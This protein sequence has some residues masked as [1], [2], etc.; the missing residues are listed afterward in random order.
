MKT[1]I[2]TF[3]GIVALGIIGFTNINAAFV[4]ITPS[5]NNK[6]V[7][8]MNVVT[9]KEEVLTIEAWMV[10][11]EFWT[12]TTESDTME[13]EKALEVEGWMTNQDLFLKSEPASALCA[14]RKMGK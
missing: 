2:R 10:E 11:N 13:S 5:V 9:E 8:N 14:D 4:N 12:L 1:N 6:G 7:E 3:I